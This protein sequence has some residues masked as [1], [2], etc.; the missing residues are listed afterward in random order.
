[1]KPW[2]L[3]LWFAC[4]AA[5]GAPITVKD[6]RGVSVT[7]QQAPR[8]VVTLLPSLTETVCQLGACGRVVGVD[9]FSNW[10]DA[11]GKLP[12]VGGLN[13]VNIE[14]VVALKPDVVLLS[15]T[16]RALPRLQQLNIPVVGLD[17]KTLDDVR[18]VS[19]IVG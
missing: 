4:A 11:V 17:I 5:A 19:R 15:S 7:V 3:A 10:P 16:A 8:R 12:H 6:D 13:D 9:D 1:M 18:R 14:R 2:L